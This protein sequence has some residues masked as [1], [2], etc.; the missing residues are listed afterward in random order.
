MSAKFSQTTSD[1]L[2]WDQ[3]LNLLRKLS[4]DGEYKIALLIAA[5]SF[6]GLRIGDILQLQ[7]NQILEKDDFEIV[8]RKTK[9]TRKIKINSQLKRFIGDCYKNM[10]QQSVDSKIFISQKG[11]VYSIQRINVI[12]KELK[13][14]YNLK[15]DN[16]STHSMRKTF[17]REVFNQSGQNAE[18]ALVKLSQIFHHSNPAITRRY[19]G[20]SQQELLDTYDTLS[21]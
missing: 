10:N 4:N 14:R 9:K 16:Y 21:F 18:I 1:F 20:I 6:W 2:S 11:T 13:S 17:G 3:N 12:F 19:L 7:F 15:I 5:G 8:E